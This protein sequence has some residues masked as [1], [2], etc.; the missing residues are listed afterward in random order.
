M[1]IDRTRGF[2]LAKVWGDCTVMRIQW[3]EMT[4]VFNCCGEVNFIHGP[5]LFTTTG[6]SVHFGKQLL[7]GQVTHVTYSA[8]TSSRQRTIS[9]SHI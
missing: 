8:G 9:L 5:D 6:S 2:G 3:T 1:S 4:R 7:K